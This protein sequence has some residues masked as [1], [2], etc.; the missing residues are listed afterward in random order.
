MDC[1]IFFVR[2]LVWFNVRQWRRHAWRVLAVLAGIALGAAV[3][4]CVRIAVAA[5]LDSFRKSMDLFAGKAEW[6][7]RQPGGAL[8][9]EVVTRLNAQD[10]VAVASPVVSRYVQVE[11]HEE[12]PCLMIGLDPFLDRGL[13]TWSMQSPSKDPSLP[14]LDLMVRPFTIALARGLADRWGVETGQTLTL[15]HTGHET[16]FR[17]VGLLESRGLALVE[18]G[19]VILADI[20]TVQEFTGTQGWVERIDLLL[21][22]ETTREQMEALQAVLPPGARLEPPS[23]VKETGNAMIRSYQLNLSVLSFASLFVGMFLVYSLMALNTGSRRREIAI[24]RSVGAGRGTV[25]SLFLAEGCA[26]GV[27]GWV[28]ALP[29]G[30]VLVKQMLVGVNDTINALFMR[31]RVEGLHVNGLE[32]L[33]SFLVTVAACLVGAWRPAWEATQVHPREAMSTRHGQ[34]PSRRLGHRTTLAGVGL[35]ALSWPLARL[36]GAPGLPLGGYLSVCFLFAGFTL[37]SPR[38]LHAVGVYL[39]PLLRRVG[40]VPAFLGARYVEVA[41]SRTAVSVG[42]LLTA[43]A[44][45]VA[46]VIMVHSFRETVDLW[47]HQTLAGDLFLRAK[48]AG[49]NAFRDPLPPEVREALETLPPSVVVLP[50]RTLELLYEDKVPYQLEAVD[51]EKL[52]RF[53][54]YM[55]VKGNMDAVREQLVSGQGV[56]VSEVFANRTGLTPGGVFRAQIGALQVEAPVLGVFRDYRTRGGLVQMALS[57]LEALTEDRQWSGARLVFPDRRQDVEEAAARLHKQITSTL[58]DRHQ[59]DMISGGRLR[60]EILRIFDETFA[61]TTVLFLIAL[62][63][64]TLGITTTLTVL[65]LERIH[66]LNTLVA[67]GASSGQIRWMVFWEAVC[68]VAVGSGMG[69]LCGFVLS[70]VLVYVIQLQSFGWTFLFRLDSEALLVAVPLVMATTLIAAFPAA[71]YAL[72]ASPALVLKEQ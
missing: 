33:L 60:R 59:V 11:G 37:L 28:L 39:P 62:G 16:R 12:T 56:V 71:R 23:L 57:R 65:V 22:P 3:F 50:Y 15:K 18:G 69:M 72:R 31:V 7:V 2:L 29:L 13:H 36:P 55:P 43:I 35:L 21:K 14:W 41:G 70:A 42:A 4:T 6:V 27:L 5:S 52:L 49:L 32:L 63:V 61:V 25:F 48:M 17:V 9:D 40:G 47:V 64:A 19:S 53:G 51:F 10:A 68:M 58:G 8:S 30:T 20:A 26:L 34:V 66:E 1:L 67:V 38:V 45:Y 54:K 44:L 46:M 24:L